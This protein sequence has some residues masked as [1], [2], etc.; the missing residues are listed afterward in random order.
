M[1]KD[2]CERSPYLWQQSLLDSWLLKGHVPSAIDVPTGL[3]KTTV[4]SIWL[5]ARAMAPDA[6]LPLRLVYVVDRRAVVD[7][8][9]I[10]AER[11]RRRLGDGIGNPDTS[12]SAIRRAL[13]LR[14]GQWLAVSTL[15]GQFADNR[16]WLEDPSTPAIVVGTVDMIGSR[17]LFEGYGVGRKMRPVHAALLGAGALVALDEAHLVPP[18]EALLKQV[19]DQQRLHRSDAPDAAVI[20]SLRM[21]SLTAT[22]RNTGMGEV[23]RLTA[24]HQSD[25]PVM[26]RLTATKRLRILAEVPSKDLAIRLAERGIALGQDNGAVLIFCN[27]RTTAQ[28]VHKELQSKGFTTG[29]LVGERR[30]LERGRLIDDPTYRRFLP[31]QD[32]L[33]DERPAFL[34]ATSAGEVG[35]DLDAD[36]MVCDLVT[37]ERMVQRLGRV[38]RRP[39]PGVASVEVVPVR[40]D[41]EDKEAETRLAD[42][43][44][45]RAPL[46]L[47]PETEAGMRDASPAAILALR[48]SPAAG[49]ILEEATSPEPLRP[50]LTPAVIEAW[51]M[52]SLEH[53]SGRPLVAPWIRGWVNDPPQTT[54]LWRRMV[55]PLPE[56]DQDRSRTARLAT[57]NAYFDAAPVHLTET[58]EAPTCRVLEILKKRVKAWEKQN[59]NDSD[60]FLALLT[61][62]GTVARSAPVSVRRLFCRPTYLLTPKRELTRSVSVKVTRWSSIQI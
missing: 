22:G 56:G 46:E 29:L 2:L 30:V 41:S 17:L 27:S 34:V 19:L 59:G 37:W 10:E 16:E 44:R 39:E 32:R 58:L 21:M 20:P 62:S 28:Q 42:A 18:F 31:G 15:R 36:H 53:H 23:F 35:L 14:S 6:G 51:A 12:V 52:T 7:Q 3:G 4:M 48:A 54:V 47:L 43:A 26:R 45:L 57:L 24:E 55:P 8:A 1:L 33:V 25:P 13:G 49:A 11:L 9:T 50:A 60:L 61:T 38:N 5:A 40:C